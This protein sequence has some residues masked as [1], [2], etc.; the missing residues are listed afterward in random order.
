MDD[1]ADACMDGLCDEVYA[2]DPSRIP[3]L[4][5]KI[6]KMNA[7]ADKLGMGPIG[8]TVVGEKLIRDEETLLVRKLLL[9]RL[10]G[11][12]PRL[13]GYTFLARVEHTAAGNILARAPEAVADIPAEFRDAAAYCDHC[14]TQRSRKDT[15]VLQTP[16]GHLMRVGRNCLA[17]YVRSEDVAVAISIW[18]L[19]SDL[20]AASD[21]DR[22]A[23]PGQ[24]RWEIPTDRYLAASFRSIELSGWWSKKAAAAADR[25]STSDAALFA[26]GRRPLDPG[27]AREWTEGQPTDRDRELA[28]A[29]LSWARGLAGASEYEHNL[30]VAASLDTVAL[31]NAG[32]VASAAAAYKR[33]LGEESARTRP[34]RVASSHF[35]SVGS[36]YVRELTVVSEKSIASNYGTVILYCLEDGSGNVFKWFSSGTHYVGPGKPMAVGDRLWFVF[37]VKKHDVYKDVAQTVITRAGTKERMEDFGFKWVGPGGI[38][39]KSKKELAACSAP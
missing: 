11:A 8:F 25:R 13:N 23:G 4:E 21:E 34:E 38:V 15:F 10:T 16:E 2:L 31:R 6:R 29:A 12:A 28:M 17:D 26:C 20:R 24:G 33:H 22:E 27:A 35:G 1:A 5:A 37:A 7:R 9:V 18:T 3:G 32:L 39:C 19:M 14:R 36:R 30:R